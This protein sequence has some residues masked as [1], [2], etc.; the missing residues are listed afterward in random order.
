[1][2]RSDTLARVAA[3]I[4][5]RRP[6]LGADPATSYVARLLAKAEIAPGDV[7]HLVKATAD[8]T[9]AQIEELVNTIYLLSVDQSEPDS[10]SGDDQHRPIRLERGLLDAALVEMAVERKARMGFAPAR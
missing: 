3:T 2:T 8:Y 7:E 9:G 1:M 5:S 4:E 10:D 6:A